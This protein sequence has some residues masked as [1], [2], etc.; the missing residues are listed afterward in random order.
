MEITTV[1]IDL[2]KNVF[3]CMPS[4]AVARSTASAV[5]ISWKGERPRTVATSNLISATLF[6]NGSF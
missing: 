5:F 3:K 6:Q 1:G 4:A 2:A